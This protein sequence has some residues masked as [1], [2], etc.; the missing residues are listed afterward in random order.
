MDLYEQRE[1]RRAKLVA[2]TPLTDLG[3]FQ[4][5]NCRVLPNRLELLHHLPGRGIVAEIGA[6]FGSYSAEILARNRPR[7]LHL[8]DA[9]DTDRYR[10]GMKEIEKSFA[11]EIR[12]GRLH[13]HQGYS[14]ARLKKFS[15]NF[16]DWVYIDTNHTYQT[17][18]EELV[19]CDAK[20]KREGHI[21]GH[22]FCTGNVVRPM[23]YGVIQAVAKFCAEYGWQ[24]EYITL[25]SH[26][27]FSFCLKR[28]GL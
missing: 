10:V 11:S 16:F 25:E 23:V 14:T 15:D 4:T 7:E 18:W 26:G 12:A 5:N 24:Y 17:T 6:A 2:D 28:L 27:H 19:L 3:Y 1:R 20:V 22:D 9:W 21:A 8:I 13:L